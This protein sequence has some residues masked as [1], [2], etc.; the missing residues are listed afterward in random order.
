M[1]T[2]QSVLIFSLM[3]LYDGSEEHL[4]FLQHHRSLLVTAC[5][6]L[7]ARRGAEDANFNAVDADASWKRWVV[8]E[9]ERRF[10]SMVLAFECL[11]YVT[12]DVPPT[13]AGAELVRALP[14][15]D[16]LWTC[17]TAAQWRQK[18][19]S[20]YRMAEHIPAIRILS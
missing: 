13:L 9:Q 19:N 3:L 10:V 12:F 20:V 18:Y 15:A 6:K 16:A 11:Q 2:I 5:R 17:S 14:C 4:L 7:I 1:S 8:M